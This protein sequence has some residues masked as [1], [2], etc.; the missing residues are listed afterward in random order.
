[1]VP[2]WFLGQVP[3]F[4][5]RLLGHAVH[6]GDLV[7][8][9]FA[10]HSHFHFLRQRIGHRHADA[11]QTA[12]EFVRAVRFLVELAAGVQHGERDLDHRAAFFLVDADRDAASVVQHRDGTVAVRRHKNVFGKARQ[13]F[14]AGVIHDFGDD[15]VGRFEIGVHAGAL[16]H[17]IK[18]AKDF[19]TCFVIC[20]HCSIGW[21]L[22]LLL[23]E[24]F[25][26]TKPRRDESRQ[27]SLLSC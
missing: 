6:E 2:V 7:L 3:I 10:V 1:M 23:L 4:R 5:Q 16:A 15:V 24:L 27:Q 12:G 20:S 18:T 9:A 25:Y 17:R 14:I 8:A 11:V 13:C 21:L 26:R 19:E 22:F